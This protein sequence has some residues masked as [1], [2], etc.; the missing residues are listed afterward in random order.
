MIATDAT[1][2]AALESQL[3]QLYAVLERLSS[4]R[5]ELV[6]A[7][8]TFWKGEARQIYDRAVAD[9]DRD[10][11]SILA[12]IHFAQQNTIIALA[13]LANRA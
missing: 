2:A 11:S 10:I 4:V 6:P 1:A 8:A 5:S 13:E 7:K 9:L 3:R 12:V